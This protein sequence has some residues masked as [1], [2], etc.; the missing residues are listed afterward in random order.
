MLVTMWVV[1]ETAVVAKSVVLSRSMEFAASALCVVIGL[2]LLYYLGLVG[3]AK[4]NRCDDYCC[5]DTCKVG[6]QSAGKC[7]ACLSYSNAAKI[8]CKDV[9]CCIG[10]AL[11]DT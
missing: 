2:L 3:I 10:R 6:K 8:D 5:N 9:E 4:E 1:N 7:M 11:E